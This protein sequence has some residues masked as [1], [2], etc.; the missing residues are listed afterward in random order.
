MFLIILHLIK[1]DISSRAI[2]ELIHQYHH[3]DYKMILIGSTRHKDD[4][5]LVLKLK[6]EVIKL[7]IQ[8]FIDFQINISF[9]KLE[10]YLSI[11]SIGLHTMWN[12]HFGI[13]IV[14]MMAAGLI[15]IAHNSA[16]PKMDI[17]QSNSKDNDTNTTC[18]YLA[19]TPIEYANNIHKIICLQPKHD[20]IIRNNAKDI[21]MKFSDEVFDKNIQSIFMNLNL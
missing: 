14:E 10:E 3:K 18:G 19:S 13:S 8:D 2:Y 17:I 11:A 12:E 21:A 7:E 20:E 5:K 1:I 16:G 15:V 9:S 4:E 6:Q